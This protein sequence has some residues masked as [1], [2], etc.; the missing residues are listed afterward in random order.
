M[1]KNPAEVLRN[2][3]FRT[4]FCKIFKSYVFFAI[5]LR[6]WTPDRTVT[7]G[8]RTPELKIHRTPDS[9]A[10]NPP[11]SR[12]LS[13][14]MGG[15][16]TPWTPPWRAPINEI[17]QC[18][19]EPT[20]SS[21]LVRQLLRYISYFSTSVLQYCPVLVNAPAPPPNPNPFGPKFLP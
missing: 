13:Q 11:D 14:K 20:N 1:I 18:H 15:L 7:C 16:W 3:V 12:L 4:F 5:F 2:L 17:T 9:G 8:L 19:I 6:F 10:K 21:R